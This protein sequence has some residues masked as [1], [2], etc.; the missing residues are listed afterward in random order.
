M[1]EILSRL[2]IR[3]KII[4]GTG[5]VVLA[6]WVLLVGYSQ[7]ATSLILDLTSEQV[8]SSAIKSVN[9]AIRDAY[10]PVERTTTLLA[11]SQLMASKSMDDYLQ[12][13]PWLAEILAALPTAAGIQVGN[14]RGDYFIIRS[15]L[16]E[17][18]LQRFDSPPGSRFS[19]DFI[20]G[21]SGD[22]ERYFFDESLNPLEQRHLPDSD[23]DPRKR[24]WYLGAMASGKTAVTTP[25]VFFFMKEIGFTIG[26]TNPSRDAVVATDITFSS[27]SKSLAAQ[28][29]TPSSDALLSMGGKVLAWS[30]DPTRLTEAAGAGLRLKT[31]KELGHPIF[32]AIEEGH[33]PKGWLVNQVQLS[34]A[35]TIQPDLLIVVPEAELLENFE[36]IQRL[37]L[38]VFFVLLLL[39]LFFIW[40]LAN[41]ISKPIREVHHSIAKVG[42]GDFEFELPVSRSQDEIGDLI[43]ALGT[44]RDS[45]KRHIEELALATAARERLESELDI[46]RRIQMNLVPGVGMLARDLANDRVYARLIPAR[47]VGGD[48]YSV[49]Q[50]DDGQ[51]F[52]AVGD[53]SDKGIPAALFMSRVVTLANLLIPKMP[54]LSHLLADLNNELAE[55]NDE[56][57]FITLFCVLLDPNTDE[58]RYAS[59]GHNPPVVISA[60][61][62]SLL[63]VDSGAPLGLFPDRSYSESSFKLTKG[64]RLVIYT[65]GITE[66]FDEAHHEFSE[67]RLLDLLSEIGN[68]GSAETLAEKVLEE[69]ADFA[70]AEPQSDDITLLV[71]E[72]V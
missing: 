35:D 40:L 30:G 66:A 72:R 27:L 18:L 24:P 46:A 32:N 9:L 7:K 61:G 34:I 21:T 42:E 67:G 63:P 20:D 45:L 38:I 44:M 22:Y 58:L 37:M 41:R 26:R 49:I 25:Y 28:R 2:S 51:F 54:D 29:I 55:N 17:A 8:F 64:Q 68:K 16:S 5:I 70:G 31:I 50:L 13:L 33:S 53:V 4:L 47:A 14:S 23:Y 39:F 62:A 48:L 15:L 6:C 12:Q 19:V 71:L 57:M 56:C 36:H 1:A 52:I 69:V 3:M 11:H 59:A 60:D 43:H 10:I 65:D